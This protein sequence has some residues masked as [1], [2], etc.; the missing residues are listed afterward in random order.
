MPGLGVGEG[1]LKA[2][3]KDTFDRVIQQETGGLPGLSRRGRLL[4]ATILMWPMGLECWRSTHSFL[5]WI[6]R[7]HPG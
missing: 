3:R 4:A 5:R 7:T 1:M 2:S 6:Q